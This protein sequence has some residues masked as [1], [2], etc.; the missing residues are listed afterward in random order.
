MLRS[1]SDEKICDH[2][3][4]RS[5]KV[6]PGPVEDRRSNKM[7]DKFGAPKPTSLPKC[8]GSDNVKPRF[9]CIKRV[10]GKKIPDGHRQSHGTQ[11]WNCEVLSIGCKGKTP[12]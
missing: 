6:I 2:V 11:A 8:I 4:H 7:S 12:V 1:P 9:L 5:R 3:N 10:L